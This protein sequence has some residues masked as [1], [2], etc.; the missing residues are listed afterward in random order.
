MAARDPAGALQPAPGNL[1]EREWRYLKRDDARSHLA[2]TLRE[3]VDGI[4][5]GLVRMGGARLDIVDRVPGWFMAGHR[6]EPTGRAPGR[7]KG[8]KDSRPRKPHERKNLPAAT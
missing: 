2:D 4:L 8:A 5:A 1:K 3:F 7:P 6:K